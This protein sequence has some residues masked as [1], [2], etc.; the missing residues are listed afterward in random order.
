MAVP[1]TK[2]YAN[3]YQRHGNRNARRIDGSRQHIASDF[4]GSQ[5]MRP[6]GRLQHVGDSEFVG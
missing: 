2:P 3:R 5:P 4:V 6:R 1:T